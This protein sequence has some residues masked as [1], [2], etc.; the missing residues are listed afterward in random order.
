MIAAAPWRH[1]RGWLEKQPKV[2]KHMYIIAAAAGRHLRGWCP[3]REAWVQLLA[4]CQDIVQPAAGLAHCC[5][6][7][8]LSGGNVSAGCSHA[9]RC[10]PISLP[11]TLIP[12]WPW[13]RRWS[14][15]FAVFACCQPVANLVQQAAKWL[16]V[17]ALA[18][19]VLLAC[20]P[21]P[22]G[23]AI[24]STVVSMHGRWLHC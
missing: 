2:V 24:V 17:L 15:T 18:A 10:V 4:A 21:Q 9:A 5:R 3:G 22:A 6:A 23:A 8:S 14:A 16:V 7:C 1:V 11:A 12:A 19:G 20:S 13:T